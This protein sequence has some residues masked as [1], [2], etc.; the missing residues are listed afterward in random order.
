LVRD[1]HVRA[2][3]DA[4]FHAARS[5]STAY[6][7]TEVGRWGCARKLEEPFRTVFGEFIET[8]HIKYSYNGDY[9]KENLEEEF[10]KWLKRVEDYVSALE[11]ER[12]RRASV[13]ARPLDR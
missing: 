3:F 10:K 1:R 9:P 6:L 11:A 5:A 2:A 12:R 8:L 13:P 4:L 7:S